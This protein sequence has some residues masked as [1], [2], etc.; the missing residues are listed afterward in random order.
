[1]TLAELAPLIHGADERVAVADLELSASF[2]ADL[3]ARLLG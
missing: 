1:M 3:P 2:F